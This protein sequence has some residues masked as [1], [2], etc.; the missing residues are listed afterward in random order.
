MKNVKNV[1]PAEIVEAAKKV[2][3]WFEEREMHNWA[4]EGCRARYVRECIGPSLGTDLDVPE[5]WAIEAMGDH[6]AR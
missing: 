4:L 3:L 6:R 5:E 1:P 2:A